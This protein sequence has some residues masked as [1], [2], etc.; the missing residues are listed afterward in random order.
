LRLGIAGGG[1]DVAPYSDEKGGAVLNTT[2]DKFAYCTIRPRDNDWVT[3]N[4]LDYGLVEEWPLDE[5]PLKYGGNFDLIKAVTNHFDIKQGFDMFIHTD[6]PVGS[7]LGGSSTVIVCILGAMS[8][9]LGV[10]M[11]QYEIAHLAYHLEREELGLKGGKQDQ[12]AAAF[13]GFNYIEFKKEDVIVT[14]LRVRK[15]ILHELH[16][17]MLLCYTGKTRES[18]NIIDSQVSNYRNGQNEAALDAA[19]RLAEEAKD[20]LLR[21]EIRRLGEILNQSWKQKKQFSNSIS[22]EYI[23]SMY[24]VAL[25]N[26][27]IGGKI[28]GAGG[29]GFMFFLC[30]YDRKHLVAR[31]L[32]RMGAITS[33]FN[34]EKDGLQT[35]RHRP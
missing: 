1:T 31:E 32:G 8:E 6:A 9:W 23:D 17:S 35:W 33:D 15:D 11:T 4:S 34:F 3:V 14:P 10:P 20:A 18:A 7:G 30:E 12:Y 25:G 26:G 27:A 19:K 24:D 21:G 16:Y 13:G 2:I 28:S 29:G 22:N 5:R